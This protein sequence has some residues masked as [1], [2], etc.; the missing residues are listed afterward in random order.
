ME[1]VHTSI[2][3]IGIILLIIVVHVDPVISLV[4]GSIYLGLAAGLGFEDTIGT[5][6]D[7]VV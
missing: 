7:G 2:A 3:I 6:A 1:A 4:L 5:I